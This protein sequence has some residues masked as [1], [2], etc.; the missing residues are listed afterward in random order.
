[1]FFSSSAFNFSLAENS[2]PLTSAGNFEA[3]DRDLGE[4]GEIVFSLDGQYS[5]R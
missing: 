5:D 4:A 1:M 2:P 3:I